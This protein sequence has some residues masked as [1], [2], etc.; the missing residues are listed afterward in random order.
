M[1]ADGAGEQHL[2][3]GA[4]GPRVDVN[5][6]D[7]AADSRSG[8]VH[9]VGL[10]ALDNLGV[11]ADHCDARA[12]ESGRHGADFGFEDCGGKAL[13]ENECD[14]HCCVPWRRKLPDHSRFR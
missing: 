8:D 14:D 12:L 6:G 11:A 10:A 5:A 13:F 1:I 4:H 7:G 3:A 9:A 2:V